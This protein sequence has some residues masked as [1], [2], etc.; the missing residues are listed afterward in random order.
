DILNKTIVYLL[1]RAPPVVRVTSPNGGPPVIT[2]SPLTVNWQR[3]Q[4]LAAQEIWYSDDA[5]ASWTKVKDVAFNAQTDAIDITAW[6]NGDRYMVRVVAYDTGPPQFKAQ[7][8]SDATFRIDRAGGDVDGPLVRPGSLRLFPNPAR[9]G[10]TLVFNATVDDS[11]RGLSN[12]DRAEY[13]VQDTAPTVFGTGTPMNAADG[14]FNSATEDVTISLIAPWPAGSLQ[15][16]WVHGLD[17]ANPTA[18]WGPLT[19]RT[20]LVLNGTSGVMPNPPTGVTAS[21]VGAAFADVRIAWAYSGPTVDKFQI[22]F[23]TA[24][25]STRASYALLQDNIAATATSWDHVSAG[26]GNANNYF[27]YVR[28]V[29][30]GGTADSAEQAA[31]FTRP[32]TGGMQLVSIPLVLQDPRIT[33]TLQT[34][35]FRTTRTY[36][37]SDGADEWKAWYQMKGNGDFLSVS[38]GM[39]LWVDVVGPDDF[40][41]A[42]RVPVSTTVNLVGGTWNFVGYG[43]FIVRPANVAFPGGLGVTQ[44]EIYAAVPQY[45]LQRAPMTTNL[46]PGRGYWVYAVTGGAWTV[47]N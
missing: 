12:L 13:W 20:F 2:S 47:N 7:D 18:N 21:L 6:P 11:L 44:L 33:T 34:L 27:Y 35:T 1:G 28:A 42:G 9:N 31:K 5:G 45:Y 36:V 26:S 43:S 23:G 46:E 15:T 14:S 16:V 38:L 19:S 17:T 39:A 41:I 10:R 24:Y 30:L 8:G 25:D 29:T 22:Y 3:S 40:T 37:A 4:P 32:M